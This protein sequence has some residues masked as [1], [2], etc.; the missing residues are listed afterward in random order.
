MYLTNYEA[1]IGYQ[2]NIKYAKKELEPK[3]DGFWHVI[4]YGSLLPSSLLILLLMITEYS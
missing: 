3:C 2:H 1:Q 4:A